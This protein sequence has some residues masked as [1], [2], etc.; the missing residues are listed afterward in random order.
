LV[1]GGSCQEAGCAPE[2]GQAAQ[3][4]AG[5]SLYIGYI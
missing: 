1:T 4:T 2:P 3:G 5:T